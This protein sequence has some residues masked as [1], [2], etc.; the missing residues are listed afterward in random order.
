MERDLFLH[1]VGDVT[2]VRQD[3]YQRDLLSLVAPFPDA[4]IAVRDV[5]T[6]LSNASRWSR[7]RPPSAR[8]PPWHS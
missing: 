8:L 1:T 6:P 2:V 3:G 5:P 4:R 7:A